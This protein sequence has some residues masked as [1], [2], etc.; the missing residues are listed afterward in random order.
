M[1]VKNTDDVMYD[2]YKKDTFNSADEWLKVDKNF[3]FFVSCGDIFKDT[4][5]YYVVESVCNGNI[6]FA[7]RKS[8]E[9]AFKIRDLFLKLKSHGLQWNNHNIMII[10]DSDQFIFKKVPHKNCELQT[11]DQFW[12][13]WNTVY[14]LPI[15][16]NW[17]Y[18]V[19][20]K[21]GKV[22]YMGKAGFI[23]PEAGVCEV[24]EQEYCGECGD[25]DDKT[26]DC[27]SCAKRVIC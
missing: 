7:K 18:D 11:I 13:K 17:N 2:G 3:Q 10:Q 6:K 12:D 25:W 9:D 22:I 8:L 19:C 24:C 15:V 23:D 4:T 16:K 1:N 26:G 14:I 20:V 5:Y 27:G 21:C